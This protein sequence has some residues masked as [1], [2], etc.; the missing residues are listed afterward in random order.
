MLDGYVT[1]FFMVLV[2][3]RASM[4][5]HEYLTQRDKKTEMTEAIATAIARQAADAL[6]Y[7][8]SR[9]LIHRDLHSGNILM[10]LAGPDISE[11]TVRLTDFG[12]ACLLPDASQ[13]KKHKGS[14]MTANVV[15]GYNAGPELLFSGLQTCR[16][17][18]AVDVW[19]WACIQIEV[20]TGG[21]PPFAVSKRSRIADRIV[22]K[23]GA[24]SAS[25]VAKHGWKACSSNAS[26][27]PSES[28]ALG[29]WFGTKYQATLR[30]ALRYDY[31]ERPTSKQ[32]F[33]AFPA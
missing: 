1:P 20:G 2:M 32:C 29:V 27:A 15:G 9:G 17:T 18:Q 25:V 26:S 31:A 21:H 3:E 6:Q 30:E 16:Y 14:K 33:D 10:C 28:L 8:H 24:P 12:M 5:L 23:L 11:T 4:N 13:G 19:A 22:A 7:V